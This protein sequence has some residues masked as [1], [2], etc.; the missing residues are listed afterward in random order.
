MKLIE[1]AQS[2]S[3]L[4]SK[5]TLRES[6]L[7]DIRKIKDDALLESRINEQAKLLSEAEIEEAFLDTVKNLGKNAFGALKA[8]WQKAKQQGHEDEM[9]RLEKKMAALKAKMGKGSG[10]VAGGGDEKGGKDKAADGSK[11]D[12]Q[13][14]DEKKGDDAQKTN[15]QAS[16]EAAQESILKLM[17]TLKKYS[18]ESYEKVMAALGKGGE[19]VEKLEQSPKIQKAEKEVVP[20]ISKAKGDGLAA[21]VDNFTR[22]TN[23][24]PV[25]IISAVMAVKDATKITPQAVSDIVKKAD[26]EVAKKA[27]EQPKQ[28]PKQEEPPKLEELP[29]K[30]KKAIDSLS[31][32]EKKLLLKLLE[33]SA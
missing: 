15:V 12:G 5:K 27:E 8:S 1:I 9:K 32:D 22:T 21:K 14:G 29:E 28:E 11:E 19:A 7:V 31:E 18:P 17:A 2:I 23:P 3:L 4:E 30:V 6:A 26:P 25:H 13:K 16:A 33:P 10:A 20:D 24:D